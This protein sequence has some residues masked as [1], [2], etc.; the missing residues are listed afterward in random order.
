MRPAAY[1]KVAIFD[2]DGTLIDSN[3]AHA[4][5]WAQA[6]REHELAIDAA[7]IRPLI[8]MGGDK[9]LP[10]L[11][12][13]EEGSAQGQAI[14]RRKKELFAATISTLRPTIGARDLLEYLG[15]QRVDLVV[16]TSADNREMTALL[17]RAGVDDLLPQRASKDDAD[18]SKPDPDIVHAALRRSHARLESSVMIGDT[19][20]DIEAASRAGIGTIALRCG[21]YWTD[22]QLSGALAIFDHPAALLEYWRQHANMPARLTI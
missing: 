11:A 2:V 14:A 8:G 17:E 18:E 20:Y 16:A 21:G 5:A 1:L 13:I 9:L 3:S 19:P 7:Q 15:T 12:S 10:A 22:D 6:L 4:E